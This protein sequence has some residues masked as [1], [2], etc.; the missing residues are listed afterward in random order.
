MIWKNRKRVF[1]AMFVLAMLATTLTVA[2]RQEKPA[3]RPA[4]AQ[5]PRPGAA[6]MERL[7]FYLGEWDYTETYPKSGFSP[8]GGKNTG[9]YTSKLG[10]GG[11]SLVNSFHSQGP[12]GDFEGLIVMTW[13]ARE[14]A[15][16]AYV[17]GNGIP[18]AV[19]ETG[20]FEGDALVYRFEF[21]VE[22]GSVKLRNVTRVTGPGTLVSEEFM[23]MK[24]APETLFVRVDAK[25]K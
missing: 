7:R 4:A 17:F 3:E 12:V 19:V 14:K 24:D 21:P 22:G 10:P 23:T 2:A 8:N 18:G 1:S 9:V 15:Y 11:Q 16:K 25:K 20:Q 5:P 6:E 13:D